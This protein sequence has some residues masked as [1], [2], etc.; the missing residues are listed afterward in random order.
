VPNEHPG[1]AYVRVAVATRLAEPTELV[2]ALARIADP[3][4]TAALTLRRHQLI[5][6]V[7][8]TLS[9]AGVIDRVAPDLAAAIDAQR[10]R[11]RLDAAAFLSV[12]GELRRRLEDR[13]AP[14]LL[15]KGLYLADRLYGGCDR[16]P[17]F[18][19]DVLV[20]PG[21][22]RLAGRCLGEMG[23]VRDDYDLHSITYRRGD[24]KVDVHGWL[25]RA[26]AYRLE[27]SRVW[28][29]VQHVRLGD[30]DVPTLS[31]EFTL[32][33][34][35]LSAVEDL[36]Q[37][38][39]RLRQLLDVLLL[40]RACDAGTDWDAFF[41]HRRDEHLDRLIAHFFAMVIDLFR[42]AAEVPRLAAA[43][44]RRFGWHDGAHRSQA[45]GL[46]FAERKAAANLAWFRDLYPGRLLWYLL[47]FW[48]GSFPRNLAV[49]DRAR[50]RAAV[51]AL[52][53]LDRT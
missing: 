9:R 22:L 35:A 2:A 25:R 32:V 40:L 44:Q 4:A 14:V 6:V 49:L 47:W 19:L 45:L 15:L 8:D 11:Q 26:P 3:P 34:M 41:A 12:F 21:H 37:G 51:G 23:F 42:G 38:M 31:D 53:R 20:R 1:E 52:F 27:T 39:A 28:R 10:P 33:L 5:G 29:E 43:L 48:A 30:A 46:V 18:D 17:Q 24:L 36:G 7:Y 13:G 50:I 16:R